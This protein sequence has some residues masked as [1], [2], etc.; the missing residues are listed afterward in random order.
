MNFIVKNIDRSPVSDVIK[1]RTIAEVKV[2][3]AYYYHQ[4]VTFFGGVPII[5]ERL[6]TGDYNTIARSSRAEVISFIL[7]DLDE[8]IPVLPLQYPPADKGRMTKGAALGIKTRVYLYEADFVNTEATAKEIIDLA[9]QAG[10][11]LNPDFR[12]M[13]LESGEGSSEAVLDIQFLRGAATGESSII[14][15]EI[16]AFL[17]VQGDYSLFELYENIG[18]TDGPSPTTPQ[19]I[20]AMWNAGLDPFKGKDPRL[21]FTIGRAENFNPSITKLDIRKASR[22][23]VLTTILNDRNN[24]GAN[25]MAI[26]YA[27]ILLMY[28]EARNENTGPDAEVIQA[29]NAVRKRASALL[30]DVPADLTKEQMR[31]FIRQERHKEFAFE[32]LWYNDLKRYG[33]TI[34]NQELLKKKFENHAADFNTGYD[35]YLLLPIPQSEIDINNNLEQNPG[36]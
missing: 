7:K 17:Q 34:I 23:G 3:R 35:K 28:A 11:A 1:Q 13:F 2:L 33:P 24:N 36:Y 27:D 8:A 15:Q 14:E 21:G 6:A 20:Q 18:E 9:P 10:Y 4:L 29:V 26:R 30:P 12:N 19:E 16:R 5:T 25:W 31:E 32:G 22:D